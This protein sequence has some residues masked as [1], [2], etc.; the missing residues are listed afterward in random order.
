MKQLF[1]RICYILLILICITTYVNS[2]NAMAITFRKLECIPELEYYRFGTSVKTEKWNNQDY[3]E[4]WEKISLVYKTDDYVIA[5]DE[6][7]V[8]FEEINHYENYCNFNDGIYTKIRNREIVTPEGSSPIGRIEEQIQ[9]LHDGKLILD[10]KNRYGCYDFANVKC[11]QFFWG[12]QDIEVIGSYLKITA[13]ASHVEFGRYYNKAKQESDSHWIEPWEG[14]CQI[15]YLTIETWLS[16][17]Q[18]SKYHT[19]KFPH[20]NE[21]IT[22]PLTQENLKRAMYLEYASPSPRHLEEWT[23]DYKIIKNKCHF[24]IELR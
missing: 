21:V 17:Y 8:P 13:A 23:F 14:G 2:T 6:E 19:I 20:T 9:F 4:L 12:I 11:D 7:A 22:L 18:D 10:S 3:K 5:Y 1:A 15:Y 16:H 24:N